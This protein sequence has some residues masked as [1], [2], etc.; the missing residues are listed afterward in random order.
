MDCKNIIFWLFFDQFGF[1]E[2]S[3]AFENGYSEYY[4]KFNYL[5][6]IGCFLT[7]FEHL[8]LQKYLKY[9]KYS[10]NIHTILMHACIGF[11]K[12]RFSKAHN[13]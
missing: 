4:F 2:I 11:A 13:L 7:K 8:K 1:D 12:K 10:H 6:I 9:F 3:L 5:A